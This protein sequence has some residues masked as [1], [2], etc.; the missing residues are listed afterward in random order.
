[1]NKL[2]SLVLWSLGLVARNAFAMQLH[3]RNSGKSLSIKVR[4]STT[5][6]DIKSIIAKLNSIPANQQTLVF[7]GKKL[8]DEYT[9]QKYRIKDNAWLSLDT[10]QPVFTTQN[11]ESKMREKEAE[12]KKYGFDNP[13]TDPK[14]VVDG[15]DE[16][17]LQTGQ[18]AQMLE[19]V[20][21]S[22]YMKHKTKQQKE[23]E[24]RSNSYDELKRK[25]LSKL[26][27]GKN[28][29]ESVVDIDEVYI[30]D[31]ESLLSFMRL[32]EV[33]DLSPEVIK[34]LSIDGFNDLPRGMVK[35]LKQRKLIKHIEADTIRGL[36]SDKR[37]EVRSNDL[38]EFVAES[39]ADKTVA[40]VC[41]DNKICPVRDAIN[42]NQKGSVVDLNFEETLSSF[43]KKQE[44]L[45]L[46]ARAETLEVMTTENMAAT[47]EVLEKVPTAD[48]E[49]EP[50]LN[51]DKNVRRLEGENEGDSEIDFENVDGVRIQTNSSGADTMNKFSNSIDNNQYKDTSITEVANT[52]SADETKTMCAKD[53]DC[54]SHSDPFCGYSCMS[55]TC[56]FWCQG[57]ENTNDGGKVETTSRTKSTKDYCGKGTTWDNASQRC[58][59]TFQ[60]IMDACKDERKEW[61][62]T[63]DMLVT[64]D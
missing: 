56:A 11:Q 27:G 32:S 7:N 35:H 12:R 5:I 25:V 53:S 24:L 57:S 21:E 38:K 48:G 49:E 37:Q 3:I 1:M 41:G 46:K 31:V 15:F 33:K 47:V 54:P 45:K 26:T 4:E 29:L 13:T 18:V 28:K 58:M 43:S 62:W 63:C 2:F 36:A 60:G 51:T 55:G 34:R 44:Y 30:K 19:A 8:R 10:E 16:E 14:D 40:L 17:M 23:T 9:L 50:H 20:R 59:A 52:E 22:E 39:S 42:K 6:E 61:G 64:C